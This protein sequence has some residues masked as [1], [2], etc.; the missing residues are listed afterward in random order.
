MKSLIMLVMASLLMSSGCG[1]SM[2]NMYSLNSFEISDD[3]SSILFSA[4][5][6]GNHSSVY[7]IET[8]GKGLKKLISST[9]DSNFFSPKYLQ[10]NKKILFIGSSF[11]SR[12][13]D[14]YIS[15]A[16]GT[17]R[18]RI[19]TG[20]EMI[21]EAFFSKC[22]SSIYYIKSNEYGHSSPVGKDQLHGADI[23]SI[24]LKDNK[25]KKV[26]QLNAYAILDISEYDCNH[27]L[28]YTPEQSKGG[29]LMIAKNTPNTI[30]RLNPVNSPRNDLS[31]AHTPVFSKKYG[32][33]GFIVPYEL[34]IM[35]LQS[36]KAKLVVKNQDDPIYSFRFFHNQK[37]LIYINDKEINFYIINFDGS[38]I[39]KIPVYLR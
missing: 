3:D 23:Y 39:K 11:K 15:H 8:N 34:Y 1:R 7:Q 35:E 36:K 17:D 22:D 4:T 30:E 16:D 38:G 10:G 12:N 27:F 31:L 24:T 19:T 2:K 18:K 14:I 26:T 21:S 13:S 32:M 29:M 37:S 28:M 6:R 33:L 5:D 25:V 20:N 9:S